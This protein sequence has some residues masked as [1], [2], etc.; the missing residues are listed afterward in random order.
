MKFNNIHD[1]Q[2]ALYEK[3]LLHKRVTVTDP[4]GKLEDFTFTDGDKVKVT[5]FVGYQ[6][7]HG[8]EYEVTDGKQ[9]A[10]LTREFLKESTP[11]DINKAEKDL[12]SILK[13]MELPIARIE[14]LNEYNL[15]WL[16]RNIGTRNSRHKDFDTAKEL[17]VHI[18]KYLTF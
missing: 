12:K 15:G 8:E 7:P 5:K 1:K 4:E 3:E 6:G 16:R 10:M 14:D 11:K 9:T 13:K 2:M 17:I 18:L